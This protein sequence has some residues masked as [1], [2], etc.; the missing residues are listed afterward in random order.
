MPRAIATNHVCSWK[1]AVRRANVST[2]TERTCSTALLSA[3]GGKELYL[4]CRVRRRSDCGRSLCVPFCLSYKCEYASGVILAFHRSTTPAKHLSQLSY[5]RQSKLISK[6]SSSLSSCACD[7][8][9]RELARC[10]AARDPLR[11]VAPKT[12]APVPLPVFGFF[13]VN[14][15]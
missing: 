7:S 1:T 6:S 13:A 8:T 14:L 3:L 11:R 12:P 2:R 15:M 5:P 9:K 10:A 4:R